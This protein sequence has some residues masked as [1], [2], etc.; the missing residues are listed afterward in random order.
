MQP[1]DK[2]VL[3]GQFDTLRSY[4]R[5]K[6][7]PD[8]LDDFLYSDA[9]QL[10]VHVVLFKD[11]TLVTVSFIHL[12]MDAMGF[13][14][15]CKG[16]TAVL[17]G[18]EDQI[19][20]IIDVDQN[21]LET[22]HQMTPSSK[23]VLADRMLTGWRFLLFVV[24]YIYELV[25]WRREEEQMIFMPAQYLSDLRASALEELNGATPESKQAAFLSESDVLCSWWIR[26]FIKALNSAPQ[27]PM[28]LL[29]VFDIRGVLA[30]MGLLPSTNTAMIANVTSPTVVLLT[31]GEILTKPLSYLA[32]RIRHAI[33]THRNP[34]Q[35]Q[36]I[37]AIQRESA[38]KTG[39]AAIFGNAGTSLFTCSNWHKG[40]LF[41]MDF[42]G[43]IVQENPSSKPRVN[44]PGRPFLVSSTGIF[45]GF[46]PRNTLAVMGKD[47]AG[48]WW[49]KCYLRAGLW[50]GIEKE[51]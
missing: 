41:Q 40:K 49:M 4:L 18:R 47:A 23:Y 42:S 21:P 9:P 22:L 17:N 3:L 24:Q 1:S 11:V 30:E 2:P 35:V 51:L 7:V 15:L 37:A 5:G 43:A 14:A 19:P 38:E 10:A 33:D 8:R 26:I 34:E 44:L 16:W 36:A 12:L 32:S 39:H 45:V 20:P 31:A 6:G 13:S 27:K 48:N 28:T 46:S 50:R 29:N 25:R